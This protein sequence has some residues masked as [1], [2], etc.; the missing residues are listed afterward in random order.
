MN[1]NT[2][3]ILLILTVIILSFLIGPTSFGAPSLQKVPNKN[4]EHKTKNNAN[5]E[6]PVN[7][8][9]KISSERH[10]FDYGPLITLFGI[11]VSASLIIWQINRQPLVSKIL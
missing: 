1:T 2:G 3:R 9:A 7:L 10:K 8:E 6:A 11:F 4:F 5:K